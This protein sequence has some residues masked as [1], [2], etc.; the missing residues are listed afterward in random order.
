M[1][2]SLWPGLSPSLVKELE[3]MNC[4]TVEQLATLADTYTGQLMN[5]NELKR[6]AGEFIAALNDQAEVTKLQSALEERDN[7]IETLQRAIE[8]QA[9][10][11]DEMLRTGQ[12]RPAPA[13]VPDPTPVEQ[14][15]AEAKRRI[16][17]K[18]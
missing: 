10:R 3:Y 7:K 12:A 2:L 15:P 8:E 16:T 17:R 14:P 11:I 13:A 18:R 5:G 6:K 1:P 4:Y 9:Q